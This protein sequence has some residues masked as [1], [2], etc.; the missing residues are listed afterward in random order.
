L[1]IADRSELKSGASVAA[2]AAT[3]P[4]DGTFTA[5][6]VASRVGLSRAS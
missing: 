5:T 6:D 4:P 3:K 2:G 1:E